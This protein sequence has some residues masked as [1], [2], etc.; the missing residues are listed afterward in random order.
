MISTDDGMNWSPYWFP[1]NYLA[2]RNACNEPIYESWYRLGNVYR[3]LVGLCMLG[4]MK[5]GKDFQVSQ[6]VFENGQP[7]LV[8]T[9]DENGQPK[10]DEFNNPIYVNVTRMITCCELPEAPYVPE[11][12]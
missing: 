8:Q 11:D 3:R 4:E 5:I 9:K 12:A 2:K 6:L 7:K 1:L 10:L